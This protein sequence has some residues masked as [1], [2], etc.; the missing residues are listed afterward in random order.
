[1]IKTML[2]RLFSHLHRAVFDTSPDEVVAFY[3]DGP[4]GYRWDAKDEFFDVYDAKGTLNRIDLNNHTIGSLVLELT[5]AGL[6]VTRLNLDVRNFSGITM[7]ELK[8][9]A[10]EPQPIILYKDIL[11]AIFGAYSREVRSAQTAVTEGIKQLYIPSAN[12]GFLDDWGNLFGVPR[13]DLDDAKYAPKIPAEAFRLRVNSYAIEKAVKDLTG[14]EI[15][16]EEPWR[17][18]FTLDSSILSGTDKFYNG[19]DTGYF[20]VQPVSY[21]AVDW[22]IVMPIIERNLAAGIQALSPLP[23]GRIF[24]GDPLD[25]TI[26][27]ELM[28]AMSWWV[29]TED[30]P[31]LDDGIR[32]SSSY[33]MAL[34]YEVA[35]TSW[36]SIWNTDPLAQAVKWSPSRINA[37]FVPNY[38]KEVLT[39]HTANWEG[40]FIEL[41]PT[42]P[43]TW[44]VGVWDQDATW[45]APYDW[46]VHMRATVEED[47]F[48]ADASG[49]L[50]SVT[51]QITAGETW[52]NLDQWNDEPWDQ[53]SK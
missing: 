11:H 10:G 39:W 8:G 6:K 23:R 50:D 29:L 7:L 17:D 43:R 35:I 24:S 31:R 41:Y 52:E 5:A 20:L 13:A 45:E 47:A 38:D 34:N 32:L 42:D 40:A 37:Y 51:M 48:H 2:E 12:D 18:I 46:K 28:S 49:L 19:T 4:T 25:G 33:R 26:W 9:E 44:Q 53:G 3:V 22:D 30:M 14:Y 16:I 21:S 1:M 27:W 36:Q 15:Q